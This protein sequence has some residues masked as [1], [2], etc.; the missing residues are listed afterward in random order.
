MTPA[1]NLL[2]LDF[3]GV[4]AEYSRP[5]RLAHL[6]TAAN[7]SP[8]HVDQTLFAS[9]L[10]LAYDGGEVATDEYLRRLSAGL[11]ATI[12]PETWVDARV[13]ACRTD[14]RVLEL[15]ARAATHMPI[16]VLTNN[17]PLMRQA[18]TRIVPTLF[19]ALQGRVLCS[20]DFGSRKPRAKVYSD[21]LA[22][23]DAR[24]AATLFV[25][26]LFVNVRGARA[27]G[28]H[29]ETAAGAASLRRVFK[30]YRLT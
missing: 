23:L 4:L 29:A 20:G 16:A 25:D 17:G 2:L 22:R 14:P 18:I 5:I 9:G 24:A 8:S 26:D 7:C 27:A 19:P 12:T 11:S 28:L 6:A 10:E 3:D 21:A 13:A 30:R 1:L 15:V